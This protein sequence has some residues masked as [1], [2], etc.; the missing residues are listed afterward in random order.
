MLPAP[1]TE[2]SKEEVKKR[3]VNHSQQHSSLSNHN[4]LYPPL[5]SPIFNPSSSNGNNPPPAAVLFLAPIFSIS[6]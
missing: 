1:S 2:A 3:S 5:P 4:L 6:T